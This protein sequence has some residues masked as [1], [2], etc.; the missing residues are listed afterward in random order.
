MHYQRD[1]MLEVML[2]TTTY[3]RHVVHAAGVT[4]FIASTCSINTK[5]VMSMTLDDTEVVHG[6]HQHV[7]RALAC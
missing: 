7:T 1:D 3:M 4:G 2:Y 6:T 5:I